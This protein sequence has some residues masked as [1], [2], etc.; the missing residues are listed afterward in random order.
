MN[1]SIDVALLIFLIYVY[2]FIEHARFIKVIL[3]CGSSFLI[4]RI[5][6]TLYHPKEKEVDIFYKMSKYFEKLNI[7]ESSHWVCIDSNVA[8]FILDMEPLARYDKGIIMNV[9][10][11]LVHFSKT[12]YRAIQK[13][14]PLLYKNMYKHRRTIAKLIDLKDAINDELNDIVYVVKFKTYAE[15][16]NVPQQMERI[17]NILDDKIKLIVKKYNFDKS[18]INSL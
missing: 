6:Q 15:T 16:F 11:H 9:I 1:L 7:D 13:D 10:L 17:T 5:V 3:A 4:W 2:V 14:D 18:V 12:Y 8:D